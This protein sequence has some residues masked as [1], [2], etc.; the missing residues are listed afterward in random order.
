MRCEWDR[1][2]RKLPIS[3]DPTYNRLILVRHTDEMVT[4]DTLCAVGVVNIL[5]FYPHHHLMVVTF[6]CADA[7]WKLNNST[8]AIDGRRNLVGKMLA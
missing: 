4:N 2:A 5:N 6:D 1:L 3:P 8:T 7:K